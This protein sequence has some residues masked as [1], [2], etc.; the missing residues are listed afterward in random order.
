MGGREEE[1]NKNLNVLFGKQLLIWTIPLNGYFLLKMKI[2]VTGLRYLVSVLL[3]FL[4]LSRKKK[5]EM[6]WSEIFCKPDI[7]VFLSA[8]KLSLNLLWS[9]PINYS[10]FIKENP[11]SIR[12]DNIG[13]KRQY[14]C[15]STNSDILTKDQINELLSKKNSYSLTVNVPVDEKSN[16]WYRIKSN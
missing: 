8:R 15:Y 13:N 5:I 2:T 9:F 7:F 3:S 12:K 14:Y 1:G 10:F 11:C 16:I 4:Y 6:Q